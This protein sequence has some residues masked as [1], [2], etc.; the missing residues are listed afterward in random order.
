MALWS[1]GLINIPCT[2]RFTRAASSCRRCISCKECRQNRLMVLLLVLYSIFTP[3]VIT[4]Q[5]NIASCC[6]RIILQHSGPDSSWDSSLWL[7][8]LSLTTL[9]HS[10]MLL[11]LHPAV[12]HSP[13]FFL[14]AS[15]PGVLYSARSSWILVFFCPLVEQCLAMLFACSLLSSQGLLPP[16]SVVFSSAVFNSLAQK[17]FHVFLSHWRRGKVT[18]AQNWDLD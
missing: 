18:K 3:N 10:L 5:T 6:P 4:P 1:A 12:L 15:H 8:L 11:A 9:A 17:W 7:S 16:L 14:T 2:V 13:Q